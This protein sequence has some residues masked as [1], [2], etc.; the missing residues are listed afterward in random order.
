MI[1]FVE[2]A[3]TTSSNL[4]ADLPLYAAVYHQG[5]NQ[6]WRNPPG[7]FF[8][9]LEKCVGHSLQLLDV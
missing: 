7:K 3:I 4:F 1:N 8:A 6:G 9:L 5:R 2:T